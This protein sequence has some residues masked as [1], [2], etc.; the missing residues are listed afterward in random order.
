MA[1]DCEKRQTDEYVVAWRCW[2][3]N[4]TSIEEYNSVQHC[5]E[6]LPEDGFQAMRVWYNDG[7]GR[8]IS[9]ND[10]YFLQEHPVGLIVGQSNDSD[11][12][13]RY[14]NASIKRG[15]HCPDIM[16]RQIN[17]LMNNSTKPLNGND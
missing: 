17:E 9:G 2:Y 7:T 4:G 13:V 11:I 10:F 15:K 14:P 12:K 16:M 6:T 5:W 8:H 1:C 3:D